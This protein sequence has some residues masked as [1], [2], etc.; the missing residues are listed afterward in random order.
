MLTVWVP[1]ELFPML[2]AG[3]QKTDSDRSKFVR[4]AIRSL[5]EKIGVR[6]EGSEAA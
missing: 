3:V 1:D 6:A 2:D 5:C 4:N